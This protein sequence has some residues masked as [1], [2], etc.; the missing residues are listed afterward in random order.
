MRWLFA[1]PN[2]QRK[3]LVRSMLAVCRRGTNHNTI[4]AKVLM[5]FFD[6]FG[7]F[8]STTCLVQKN[9]RSVRVKTVTE[10]VS[11]PRGAY[12]VSRK[13]IGQIRQSETNL[14]GTLVTVSFWKRYAS[15]D[16]RT[17]AHKIFTHEVK[18]RLIFSE[19]MAVWRIK[20]LQLVYFYGS[21]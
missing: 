10:P 9:I 5:W 16:L 14:I 12:Y 13:S 3:E 19:S 21:I 15:H 6:P 11:G 7:S 2:L 18:S 17:Y 20:L 1:A 8:V 4:T